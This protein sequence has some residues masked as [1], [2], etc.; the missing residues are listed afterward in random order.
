M[1]SY[2][3]VAGD[4]ISSASLITNLVP[5]HSNKSKAAGSESWCCDF[6]S[7]ESYFAWSSGNCVVT[8][9]PWSFCKATLFK[10]KEVNVPFKPGIGILV[11]SKHEV[12]DC[13][14]CNTIS[15]F[16]GHLIRSVAF[17]SSSLN[18]GDKPCSPF[19]SRLCSSKDLVLA[20]GHIN[21]RIRI[22][23]VL[24][25]KLI[26]QLMD[27]SDM[28]SHMTFNPLGNLVLISSSYDGTLKVWDLHNDGNMFRTLKMNNR[29]VYSCCW[30]H[31]GKTVVSV[32]MCKLVYVWDMKSLK[33]KFMLEGHHHD[34]VS[35][36]FSPDDCLIA[37]ASWDTRVI[38]WDSFNGQVLKCF[39]HLQPSPRLI[40]ACGYNGTWIRD[41]SF[42]SD[43][44]HIATV[45]DD[46]YLRFWDITKEETPEAMAPIENSL[47]CT[48]SPSG[49]I[50]AVGSRSG[51]VSFW[52]APLCVKSLKYLSRIAVRKSVG[53]E[54][55][56]ELC[57]P[58]S[59]VEY[60]L[61]KEWE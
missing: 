18:Y 9:I 1:A 39:G 34:V 27:H 22:W 37:S 51:P 4:E 23:D 16:T 5:I 45:A 42:S 46:G 33:V 50:L 17:G 29:P 26:L 53:A 59:L 21:G 40:F 48:Y 43:G 25:G 56:P 32:G 49:R 19:W 20:T 41:V 36:A 11:D 44:A 8:I 30:S 52:K 14:G 7:D 55:V 35:C 38:L 15:V 3:S 12:E 57:I 24:T 61:Y 2:R 58:K 31:D 10:H 13:F 60:L 28:V 47:C 6:S 54:S